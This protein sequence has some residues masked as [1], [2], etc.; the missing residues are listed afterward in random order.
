[1]YYFDAL[2]ETD[3]I[4]TTSASGVTQTAV[5]PDTPALV[6]WVDLSSNEYY[7]TIN[8][9]ASAKERVLA[10]LVKLINRSLNVEENYRILQL[11]SGAA[12]DRSNIYNF[13]S[14]TSRFTYLNCTDMVDG[15][16]DY[17]DDFV[18]V[19]GTNV[20]KDIIQWDWNDNKYTSLK[21]AFEDLKINVIRINQTVTRDT[22][23]TL[24][25]SKNNAY[26]IGRDTEM[27][28]PLLFARKK[29]NS[30][31]ILGG[32]ISQ[33]GD[34]PER[35][36]FVSPNPITVTSTARYLAVGVVGFEQIV[37]VVSN[38]Y[39]IAKFERS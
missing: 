8:N 21:A 15:V 35:L 31:E 9:L 19:A 16:K 23:S 30:I 10:R 20:D 33:A 28:K 32:I 4:L 34:Q 2:A 13:T 25:L 11:C 7:V 12:A 36:V 22:V 17:A 38:S 24:I 3:T 14:G 26:L 39:A 5:T 6:T 29:L 27:G 18:L 37:G 1:V